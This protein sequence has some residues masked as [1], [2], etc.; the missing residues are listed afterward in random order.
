[1]SSLVIIIIKSQKI[2]IL[3][4]SSLLLNGIRV[5]WTCRWKSKSF[6]EVLEQFPSRISN[7]GTSTSFKHKTWI[8]IQR[9]AKST[10]LIIIV[11]AFSL[12][13]L[14]RVFC[15]DG[16]LIYCVKIYFESDK[17]TMSFW[18]NRKIGNIVI[19]ERLSMLLY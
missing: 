14:F 13:W 16:I 17:V 7:C 18:D 15:F 4:V 19:L 2:I 8:K 9:D 11:F 10:I 3:T 5:R 6:T 1:M 12:Q